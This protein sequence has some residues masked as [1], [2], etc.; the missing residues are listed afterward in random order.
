LQPGNHPDSPIYTDFQP[1][2][3]QCKSHR[4]GD[5]DGDTPENL[6]AAPKAFGVQNNHVS[7]TTIIRNR[8][9]NGVHWC[10][11]DSE[12]AILGIDYE[13]CFRIQIG[14]GFVCRQISHRSHLP[15]GGWVSQARGA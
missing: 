4:N 15:K 2:E 10:F 1:G 13:A 11:S 12:I 3:E 14:G 5:E 6:T 8:A 9:T 7:P